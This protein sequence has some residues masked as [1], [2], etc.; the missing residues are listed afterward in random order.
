MGVAANFGTKVDVGEW[1]VG[2]KLD[3]VEEVGAKGS[4]KVVRVFAEVG[5]L[6]EEV[7]EIS[8]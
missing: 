2:R 1:S 3:F 7:D 6:W 8:N 4:D 5:V